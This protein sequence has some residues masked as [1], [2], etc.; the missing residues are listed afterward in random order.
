MFELR[1]TNSAM[2]M[3]CGETYFGEHGNEK[4]LLLP[5]RML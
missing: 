1:F 2:V 5:R 4:M 3:L